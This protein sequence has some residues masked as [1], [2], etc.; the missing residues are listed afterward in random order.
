MSETLNPTTN[1]AEFTVDGMTC[2]N[3]ARHVTE[4]LQSVPEVGSAGVALESGR[5][6]VRW[7]NP[8][9][10]NI[11]AAIAVLREAGYPA[12]LHD[13]DAIKSKNVFSALSSW[14]ATALVGMIALVPMLAAEWIFGVAMESWYQWV[15]FVL[16]TIVQVF[17]GARF[18]R[19]AWAQLKI[20]N[21]NMDTLVSLGS[22]TAYI[23]SLW[24]LLS[25]RHEH[26]YF[27]EAAGIITLVSV[28]HW[29]EA[30]AGAKASSALEKLLNLA[31][32]T[33]RLRDP[34]SGAER[35]VPVADLRENDTILL[36]PGNR[37]PVDGIV[38]E[39]ASALDESM[40]TGESLP[41]DKTSGDQIYGGTLNVNGLIAV[42]VTAV[43]EGTA[44][45]NIIAA[46]QRAQSSRAS[47]QRL[48][49]KVSSIFVPIVVVIAIATALW[50]GL[51]FEGAK[52]LHD[53]IAPQLWM[54]HFPQTAVAAAFIFAAAVLIVACPCAM[55][56]ATPVA[57]MAGTNAAA[58]RG[59]LIRDGVALEKAGKITA[60]MFDKTGTLTVG[61]PSVGDCKV[62][63][64]ISPEAGYEFQLAAALARGSTHPLSL[65]LAKTSPRE[66]TFTNWREVCGSGVAGELTLQNKNWLFRLGSLK[67][68]QET[69]VNVTAGKTFAD[70]WMS[71]GATILGLSGDSQLIALI[72][73]RDTLKSGAEKV[74]KQLGAKNLQVYLITGD[75]QLTAH[76]IAQQIGLKPENVFAEIRPEQKA[77]LVKKLQQK[78]ERVAFVGDGIN[79]AP[80]LEQA[81]LGIAVSKASDVA[82]EAADIILLKSEIEAIPETLGLAGATLRTIKQNLF[83][84][85]FYNAA[86]IPLAAL[87]FMSPLLC[88]AAMGLS[89][90]IVIGNALRL[91]RW[92][93]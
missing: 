88:A 32:Q 8:A 39:G 15:A 52:K 51:N 16:A 85:F 65:A 56:L 89:D 21:S 64:N 79:D 4:A 71:Q 72:A 42:R 77:D 22:T 83:W 1:I 12:H 57:I 27:M 58:Q 84:A 33:A 48:G 5:A 6:T 86:A 54:I 9:Q 43:G 90:L 49:D 53:A 19:G 37:V 59:I 87:G 29:L 50:W 93:M 28:G 3:C 30:R 80:A 14:R 20:G 75:N 67:W 82:H 34:Q 25:G 69:G 13:P 7:R 55:G 62:L 70:H 24:V 81:D 26:V 68:L 18:Y 76:A 2:G 38:L 44:L 35:E 61:K 46:V 36:R 91:R 60:V 40:L 10:P 41:M 66:I 63:Q 23:Y 73:L 74:V 11:S 47:I 31:P 17:G 78:G 92:K 45:A